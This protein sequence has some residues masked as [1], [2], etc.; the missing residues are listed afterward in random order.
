METPLS[1]HG[2]APS[3]WNPWPVCI[4]AWFTL[5]ILGCGTFIFFCNR[6]PADLVAPDYYEQ[7]VRYQGQIE[8]IQHARQR[9]HLASVTYDANRKL[10]RIALPPGQDPGDATGSIQLY[11]PSAMD[12]DRQFNLKPGRDGVQTIQTANLRP[13]LWEVRVS[14]TVGRQDYFI[15]QRVFIGPPAS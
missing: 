9:A 4:I 14:W 2:P 1:S 15:D 6:Y 5:A 7:E 11:R 10:I 3:R 13:G 12:Q 8:R